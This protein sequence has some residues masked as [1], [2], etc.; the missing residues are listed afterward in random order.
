MLLYKNDTQIITYF[1]HEINKRQPLK[2]LKDPPAQNRRVDEIYLRLQKSAP[3][4]TRKWLH[5]LCVSSLPNAAWSNRAY[6]DKQTLLWSEITPYYFKNQPESHQNF[7]PTRAPQNPPSKLHYFTKTPIY[8]RNHHSFWGLTPVVDCFVLVTGDSDQAGT[9]Y[10][11]RHEFGK[12]VL[13]FNPHV[14]VSEHLKRAATYYKH[15]PRDLPEKCQLPNI[16]PIGTHGR[17]IHRP[18]AWA[19]PSSTT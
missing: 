1:T 18:A 6:T 15:I 13:V 9:V 7:H 10:A 4:P 8:K 17:T 11:L 2:P 14:A 3:F 5:V 19:T 12:S 16:I